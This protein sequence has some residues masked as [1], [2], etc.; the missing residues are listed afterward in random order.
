[1]AEPKPPISPEVDLRNFKFMPLDVARLADSDL[2][3]TISPEAFRA[4]VLLWGK[5]WHQVPAGSLPN[6]DQALARLAQTDPLIFK[7]IRDDAL[8][9]FYL[10]SDDR[11]YHSLIV[12]KAKEAWD[13][14]ERYRKA[15][16]KRWKDKKKTND[17][18]HVKLNENLDKTSMHARPQ[19]EGEG[20][21]KED[22]PLTPPAGV[23]GDE[24]KQPGDDDLS[25]PNQFHVA[26]RRLV[27]GFLEH[28][29]KLWP[30]D[31][32]LTAPRTT[33]D[34]QAR[35][36]IEQ[37]L[38]AQDALAVLLP[39]MSREATK[40]KAPPNS[41]SA[42]GHTL[43]DATAKQSGNGPRA[44]THWS[45]SPSPVADAAELKL[46]KGIYG[47]HWEDEARARGLI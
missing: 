38:T 20:P 23:S 39:A 42:F 12:E 34:S 45:D 47:E 31:P 41:L 1:M 35:A 28:R 44:K 13:G 36:F 14:K 37:G 30:A 22:P 8:H 25:I 16:R 17:A 43:Q 10:C 26:T 21:K 5:S 32:R 33:L 2:T 7:D 40:G 15:A 18:T 11:L 46:I 9:G 24:D 29:E 19:R 6:N 27:N 4:A 3:L